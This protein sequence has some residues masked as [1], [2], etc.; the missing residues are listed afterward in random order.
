MSP[1]FEIAC[2][3]ENQK[4]IPQKCVGGL[5]TNLRVSRPFLDK[6]SSPG[7]EIRIWPHRLTAGLAALKL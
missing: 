4:E 2:L 7:G 1:T 5:K 3:E 6:I